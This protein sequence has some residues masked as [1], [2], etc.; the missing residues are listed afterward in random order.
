MSAAEALPL[1]DTSLAAVTDLLFEEAWLLDERRFDAW[2]DLYTQDCVY[3]MPARWGQESRTDEVSLFHDDHMTLQTR[4]GRLLHPRAHAQ[5]P[6]SRTVHVITNIRLAGMVDGLIRVQSAC[7]FHEFRAPDRTDLVALVEHHLRIEA[8]RLRIA[9]K[10][11]DLIDCDQ[12]HRSL[13]VP[14]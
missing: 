11:V 1:V 6:P 5:L 12:P 9:W 13:Q 2:L 10:R 14:I 3:W 8:G 4:I 7:Q